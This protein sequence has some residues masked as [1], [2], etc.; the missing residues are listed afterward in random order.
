MKTTCLQMQY[1]CFVFQVSE[2]YRLYIYNE[3]SKTFDKITGHYIT[4]LSIVK[5]LHDDQRS[6]KFYETT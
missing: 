3:L 1:F 2:K 6:L 5:I 4:G